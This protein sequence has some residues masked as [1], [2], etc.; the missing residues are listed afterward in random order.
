MKS[1]FDGIF[2]AITTGV[3]IILLMLWIA[4]LSSAYHYQG[5]FGFIYGLV[6]GVM[7]IWFLGKKE[8]SVEKQLQLKTMDETVENSVLNS[9]NKEEEFIAHGEFLKSKF[10][11]DDDWL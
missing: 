9:G 7:I 8:K 5:K 4:S 1:L 6:F 3:K 11:D 2:S 10:A